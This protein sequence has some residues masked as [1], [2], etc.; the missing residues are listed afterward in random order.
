MSK[1][2]I[3]QRALCCKFI[4]DD[5]DIYHYVRVGGRWFYNGRKSLG[6]HEVQATKSGFWLDNSAYTL[7]RGSS[8]TFKEMVNAAIAK[9][10]MQ[11]PKFVS[12]IREWLPTGDVA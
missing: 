2:L 10:K 3:K 12:F 8:Y 4:M 7:S 9:N 5:G 11:K 6:L 1:K